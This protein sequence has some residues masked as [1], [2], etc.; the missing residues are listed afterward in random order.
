MDI[1]DLVEMVCWVL[2]LIVFIRAISTWIS[3]RREHP[4]LRFLDEVTDP[5]LSP[6][7]RIVP[8]TGGVDFTPMVALILLWW[9][10]PLLIDMMRDSS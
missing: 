6:L 1:F 4:V 3:P 9:V 7:R 5:F 8:Q 2:G 10:I